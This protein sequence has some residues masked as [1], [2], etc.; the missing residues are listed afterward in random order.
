MACFFVCR[1]PSAILEVVKKMVAQ[2]SGKSLSA[3]AEKEAGWMLIGAL[4]S[5]MPKQ[6]QK[7]LLTLKVSRLCLKMPCLVLR[8]AEEVLDENIAAEC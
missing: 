4:V 7:N 3:A 1:L 8:E 2:Q 6:V 5:S